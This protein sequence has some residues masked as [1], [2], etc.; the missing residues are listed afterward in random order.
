MS[1][2]DEINEEYNTLISGEHYKLN[3]TV[4]QSTEKLFFAENN[5][6]LRA[7]LGVFYFFNKDFLL[8]YNLLKEEND[9]ISKFYTLYSLIALGYRDNAVAAYSTYEHNED[10]LTDNRIEEKQ[11]IYLAFLLGLNSC[12]IYADKTDD[13]EINYIIKLLRDFKH[14]SEDDTVISAIYETN[15]QL[16]IKE[17]KQRKFETEKAKHFVVHEHFFD[18]GFLKVH[19]NSTTIGNNM[20]LLKIQG[21]CVIIDCG[22]DTQ[23]SNIDFERFFQDA[24]VSKN[25]VSAV[26]FTHAHLDHIGNALNLLK[27]L[28]NSV[29]YYLTQNTQDL[30]DYGNQVNLESKKR[31]YVLYN[32]SIQINDSLNVNFIQNGHIPGSYALVF[33]CENKTIVFT[34]DFCIHN[35]Q[36]V[37]GMDMHQLSSLLDKNHIDYL[38]TESTY[39]KKINT[40]DYEDSEFLLQ[41]TVDLLCKYGKKVFLPAYAIGRTQEIINILAP[42]IENNH[43]ALNVLGSAY[44]VTQYYRNTLNLSI[45]TKL[46]HDRDNAINYD[47]IVA[48]AGMLLE[49]S[50]S[51]NLMSTLL[52]EK[53]NDFALIQTGYMPPKQKGSQLIEEW[54]KAGNLFFNISLSAHASNSEIHQLIDSF[55]I[56]NIISIHGNGIE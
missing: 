14:Y 36:L 41:K 56:D 52:K 10:L 31:Y 5:I 28:G 32:K 49:N 46:Y 26:F 27:F 48:S 38:I 54:K 43:L 25:D 1:I 7:F 29:N 9:V 18:D 47:I 30:A 17:F 23:D 50:E 33:Y 37:R 8:S 11:R 12:Y 39:G 34:S 2:L 44:D 53:I 21:T 42:K 55:S 35:Q 19:S 16:L 4:F 3:K 13:K 24:G 51:Y 20:Y 45:K 40:I 15:N 22:A 6:Y